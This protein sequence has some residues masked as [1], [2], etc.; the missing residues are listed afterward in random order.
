M[1]DQ[2]SE[3]HPPLETLRAWMPL[4]VDY[5]AAKQIV[6]PVFDSVP[7]GSER[8]YQGSSALIHGAVAALVSRAIHSRDLRDDVDP[9][10]MLLPLR[11][12]SLVPFSPGWPDHA[13]RLVDV[14]IRGSRPGE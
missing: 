8:L 6:L 11:S 10:E 13:E 9:R 4:F 7:G 2:L 1:A 12:V 14:L 3:L 5:V